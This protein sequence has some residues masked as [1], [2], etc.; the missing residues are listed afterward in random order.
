MSSIF[1]WL[2]SCFGSNYKAE[3][4]LVPAKKDDDRGVEEAT[5]WK[6]S[7]EVDPVIVDKGAK[8]IQRYV[9]RIIKDLKKI[10]I[11]SSNKDLVK[12][13]LISIAHW[14]STV[15]EQLEKELASCRGD[16]G[17][18]LEIRTDLAMLVSVR[19]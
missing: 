10:Q 3:Y 9:D 2:A 7:H 15:S 18:I 17:V 19:P 5:R 11:T 16:Q 6:D 13:H 8:A 14:S 4:Q 12:D 1:Q